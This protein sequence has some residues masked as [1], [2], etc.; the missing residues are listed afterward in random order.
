MDFP[1]YHPEWGAALSQFQKIHLSGLKSNRILEVL[2]AITA[3]RN[4]K[5]QVGVLKP[6]P[7]KSE[8]SMTGKVG[9]TSD[10]V[11]DV[12]INPD[13]S[14]VETD[15]GQIDVN[16]RHALYYPE[17]RPFFLEGQDRFAFAA[18]PEHSPLRMMVHTRN[19]ADPK[20]GL[21]LNGKITD[22]DYISTIYAQDDFNKPLNEDQPNENA[23]VSRIHDLSSFELDSTDR[24]VLLGSPRQGS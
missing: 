10:L 6:D 9:L 23:H 11:I 15:A 8:L 18:N 24:A 5:H 19:I 3:S 14:Q 22:R 1:E 13:F 20:M 16:L 12:T 2:P 17:K 7:I 4:D 21:K